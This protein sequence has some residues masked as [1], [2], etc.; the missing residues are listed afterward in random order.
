MLLKRRERWYLS[1]DFLLVFFGKV[2]K[3]VVLGADEERDRRFVKAS[4]L[5]IPF[6]NRIQ[7]TL[8]S[9]IE[10]KKYSNGVVADEREHVDK[11]S[12]TAQIPNGEGDF[13]IS[14]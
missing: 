9:K 3:V 12:L 8:P 2:D 5:P 13:G 11:L 10:H 14:Y 6:F 7:C 1:G 4:S